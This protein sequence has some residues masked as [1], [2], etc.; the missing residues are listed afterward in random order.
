MNFSTDP[1]I[2]DNAITNSKFVMDITDH[3]MKPFGIR[4]WRY[5]WDDFGIA[6]LKNYLEKRSPQACSWLRDQ[7][8]LVD[9]RFYET[10]KMKY[11][12]YYSDGYHGY[13]ENLSNMLFFL[14]KIR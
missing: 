3:P 8:Y 4:Y 5:W 6:D 10:I 12:F 11:D 13:V 7:E 14:P 1:E 9:L 2:I